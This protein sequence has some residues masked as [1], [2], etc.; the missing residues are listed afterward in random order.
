MDVETERYC[1]TCKEKKPIERF[2]FQSSQHLHRRHQCMDCRQQIK[3]GLIE[4]KAQR[5]LR[6]EL[7]ATF[8][9]AAA[10]SDVAAFSEYLEGMMGMFGGPIGVA[11]THF[12]CLQVAINERPGSKATLDAFRD[13]IKLWQQHDAASKAN[14][15]FAG[16]STEEI[17]KRL[18]SMANT[19]FKHRGLQI[20]HGDETEVADARVG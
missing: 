13:F 15:D 3:N 8:Q 16:L 2:E 4:N 19:V 6:E 10:G 11:Q 20:V 7:L 14:S 5:K 17:E 1:V 18:V 9:Q 12:D